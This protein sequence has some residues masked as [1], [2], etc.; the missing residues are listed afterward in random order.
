MDNR[1]NLSA[2]QRL[3]YMKGK[4]YYSSDDISSFEKI[5]RELVF[6]ERIIAVQGIRIIW[7]NKIPTDL[8]RKI[9]SYI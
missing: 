8:E 2:D 3:N 1:Y 5:V 9:T 6:Q 7:K 4:R